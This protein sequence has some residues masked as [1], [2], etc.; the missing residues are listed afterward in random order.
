MINNESP[1][2][3]PAKKEGESQ[4]VYDLK[5]GYFISRIS[6]TSPT[7]FR[8]IEMHYTECQHESSEYIER[9][10]V[11]STILPLFSFAWTVSRIDIQSLK[12]ILLNTT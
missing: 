2:A 12:D 4:E 9:L 11:L 6:R 1:G 5:V 10:Y 8:S 7:C 3:S